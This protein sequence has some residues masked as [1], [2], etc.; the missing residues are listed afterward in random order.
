MLEVDSD[1]PWEQLQNLTWETCGD[2]PCE[3]VGGAAVA[4][5][6][7][8][9]FSSWKSSNVFTYN[10]V[11]SN[12]N[13][14]LGCPQSDF[15]LAV[16]NNLP[17]AVGGKSGEQSTDHL[18]S[19]IGDKWKTVFP[20]MPTKRHYLAVISARNYLIAAG[21]MG[22]KGILSTVEVMDMNTQEW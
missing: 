21:G 1:Q 14:L 19:F 22:V 9:Y 7:F 11:T 15:G 10:P 18:S 5:G 8:A 3:M 16:I 4:H 13:K 6:S 2:A 12:W 20:P 17:T